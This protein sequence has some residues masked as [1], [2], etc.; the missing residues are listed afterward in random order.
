[1][2]VGVNGQSILDPSQFLRLVSDSK[3]GA[4]IAVK[5]LRAGRTMEFKLAIVSN[6]T[7]RSR[8]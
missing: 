1:V 4:T 3:P 6:A 5:V 8:R 7:T 2:I